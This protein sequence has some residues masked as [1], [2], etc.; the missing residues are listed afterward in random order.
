M[1]VRNEEK[2]LAK[3]FIVNNAEEFLA[4][5][6]QIEI[7][8]DF[9]GLKIPQDN[10]IIIKLVDKSI[11]TGG[12]IKKLLAKMI[13]KADAFIIQEGTTKSGQPCTDLIFSIYEVDTY[14][15]NIKV[16]KEALEELGLL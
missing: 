9:P 10:H 6:E 15:P 4:L 7:D 2:Y 1:W 3:E 14:D 11:A 8:Y 12:D 16:P 13:E 5:P